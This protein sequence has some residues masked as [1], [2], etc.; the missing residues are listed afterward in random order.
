MGAVKRMA[1]VD[2][3]LSIHPWQ[4]AQKRVEWQALRRAF[5]IGELENKDEVGDERT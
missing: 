4:L 3:L 5:P 2:R 1:E